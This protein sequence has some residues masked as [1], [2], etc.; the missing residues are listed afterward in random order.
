MLILSKPSLR[1]SLLLLI[2]FI[3]GINYLVAAGLPMINTV[4]QKYHTSKTIRLVFS[5][6]TVQTEIIKKD[7]LA[8]DDSCIPDSLTDTTIDFW[9]ISDIQYLSFKHFVNDESEKMFYQAWLK[10]A[11][12]KKISL[13]NDSLRKVYASSTIEVKEAIAIHILKN[14]ENS[15]TLNQEISNLAQS[16]REQE[17]QYWKSKS[18]TEKIKFQEKVK[19]YSDSLIFSKQKLKLEDKADGLSD[20]LLFFQQQSQKKEVKSETTTSD[21]VYKIQ[22]V[23]Y[24]SKL[25]ESAIAMIKKLS[26]LRKVENYIDEKGLK[27][28]TTGNLKTYQEA[29][30]M[31]T[32]VKQEGAKNATI[33]AFQKGKKITINEARKINNEL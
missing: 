14:E 23:A 10:E 27:I 13:Q 20:T 22:I 21:I 12:L 7:T 1:T 24:K 30:T 26:S 5:E 28:Y 9:V 2:L 15:A 18:S 33:I 19:M 3:G 8:K 29:V 4:Q 16:A 25:P 6:D 11:E 32:Q 31:Q 17:Y